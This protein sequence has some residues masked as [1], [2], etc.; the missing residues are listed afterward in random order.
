LDFSVLGRR[1]LVTSWLMVGMASESVDFPLTRGSIGTAKPG[2]HRVRPNYSQQLFRHCVPINPMRNTN[3]EVCRAEEGGAII[4]G[5][6]RFATGFCSFL[7][8]SLMK[9][10]TLSRRTFH[11]ISASFIISVTCVHFHMLFPTDG[12]IRDS[13]SPWEGYRAWSRKACRRCTMGPCK[14]LCNAATQEKPS[15]LLTAFFSVLLA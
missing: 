9:A 12:A 2:R 11:S 13:R 3:R 1:P 15:G 7:C 14:N 5:F 4:G 10:G 8:L 6:L